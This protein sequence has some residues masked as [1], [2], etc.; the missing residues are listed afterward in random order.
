LAAASRPAPLQPFLCGRIEPRRRQLGRLLRPGDGDRGVHHLEDLQAAWVINAATKTRTL[1]LGDRRT[2]R[3]LSCDPGQRLVGGGATGS[4]YQMY[5]LES[6]PVDT[7]DADRTPDAWQAT[8]HNAR[9][10][11]ETFTVHVLCRDTP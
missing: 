8:I 2:L 1:L 6:R 11:G 5:L 7:N 4:D 9:Q 3:S 10:D